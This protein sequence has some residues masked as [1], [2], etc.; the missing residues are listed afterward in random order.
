MDNISKQRPY[1]TVQFVAFFDGEL[2]GPERFEPVLCKGLGADS[3][4]FFWNGPTPKPQL[5]ITIGS[6]LGQAFMHAQVLR[7]SLV[8][9]NGK[10]MHRVEC[11]F[12][13]RI[14]GHYA[15]NAATK[16]VEVI[17]VVTEQAASR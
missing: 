11:G 8:I 13:R 15:W 17:A 4:S 14:D 9:L 10:E 16:T 2:P 12:I 5:V 1:A 6:P 3:I 7:E